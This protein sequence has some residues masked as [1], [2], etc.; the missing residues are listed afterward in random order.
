MV[1]TKDDAGLSGTAKLYVEDAAVGEVRI[2]EATP[3]SFSIEDPFDIGMDS[4]SAVVPDYAPPYRY[5][6]VIEEVVFHLGEL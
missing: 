4:G 5:S 6:G 3:N 1:F 2:E